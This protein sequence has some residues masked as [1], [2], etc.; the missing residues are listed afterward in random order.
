MVLLDMESVAG[1]HKLMEKGNVGS[2]SVQM[3]L[4]ISSN[5]EIVVVVDDVN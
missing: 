4:R 3:A 2:F 1:L 5:A